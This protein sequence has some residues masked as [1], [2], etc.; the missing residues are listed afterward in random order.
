MSKRRRDLLHPFFSST[1]GGVSIAGEANG[2]AATFAEL[3]FAVRAPNTGV[4]TGTKG[5]GAL[6]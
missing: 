2:V 3:G 5:I 1:G 4:P 6:F